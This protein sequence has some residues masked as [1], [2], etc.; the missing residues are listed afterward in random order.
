MD[1]LKALTERVSSSKLTEP[2][3]S[4]EQLNT[5]FKAA[6]RAPDHANLRP[7]R[8]ITIE[9]NARKKLGDLFAGI[10]LQDDSKSSPAIVERKRNAPFRAPVIVALVL[11]YKEH[12]KVPEVEQILSVGAAGH[13]LITAAYQMGLGAYWRTGDIC[14]DPRVAKALDLSDNEKLLGFV[15]LGTP[16]GALKSVPELKVND[17]VS[18][19]P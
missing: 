13:G 5:M 8:F 6:L 14:F 9:G 18:S 4:E 12:A 2:G 15:Y 16:E 7:W 11:H 17:F 3:P 1:V 10:A 19:W